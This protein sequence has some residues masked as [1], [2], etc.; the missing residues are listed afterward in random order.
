MILPSADGLCN[1]LL[2]P[3]QL[4]SKSALLTPWYLSLL[5]HPSPNSR[6]TTACRCA[7]PRSW[8]AVPRLPASNKPR[9]WTWSQA[10]TQSPAIGPQNDG[11]LDLELKQEN[12][13]FTYEHACCFW[14]RAAASYKTLDNKARKGTPQQGHIAHRRGEREQ[15]EAQGSSGD[16][17][18]GVH[19]VSR[20]CDVGLERSA[21]RDNR[22]A[23]MTRGQLQ[24]AEARV[25]VTGQPYCYREARL[26][27]AQEFS[28]STSSLLHTSG[29]G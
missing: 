23:K 15:R 6:A 21:H 12:K 18:V 24:P 19:K 13:A 26:E 3:V 20:N 2:T 27:A 22:S 16:W 7:I 9:P 8:T 4:P 28:G 25:A 10:M 14:V 29:S 5:I 11:Q 1:H 17:G